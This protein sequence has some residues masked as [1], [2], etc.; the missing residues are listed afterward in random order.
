MLAIY[1]SVNSADECI[2]I[3]LQTLRASPHTLLIICTLY[4]GER[5][6][7]QSAHFWFWEKEK[8]FD[9]SWDENEHLL[10]RDSELKRVEEIKF[11]FAITERPFDHFFFLTF[12]N[13]N[14][15]HDRRQ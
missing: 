5:L 13:I 11:I 7:L 2:Q 14:K 15:L 9:F 6:S 4:R 3:E 1:W 12:H 8:H 10:F